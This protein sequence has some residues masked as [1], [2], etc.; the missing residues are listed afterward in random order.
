MLSSFLQGV[1][2]FVHMSH[3]QE[4]K[5]RLVVLD[6]SLLKIRWMSL[7]STKP[8]LREFLLEDFEVNKQRLDDP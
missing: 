5:E 7:H 1:T 3:D 4:F 6:K 8:K 2:L